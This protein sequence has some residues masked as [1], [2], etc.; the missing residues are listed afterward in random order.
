V[1][2]NAPEFTHHPKQ[3]ICGTYYVLV[4]YLHPAASASV[5]HNLWQGRTH[6]LLCHSTYLRFKIQNLRMA[7]GHR[8]ALPCGAAG[9]T[10]SGKLLHQHGQRIF[11]DGLEP[12]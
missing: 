3:P 4:P 5:F 11:Q 10:S 2:D 6:H 9:E 7:A 8:Q 12:A 1:T